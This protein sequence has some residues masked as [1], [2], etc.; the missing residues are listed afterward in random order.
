[1]NL[2]AIIVDDEPLAARR[3]QI[4]LETIGGVELLG[5]A[6]DG[7]KALDLVRSSSPDLI[8]LDIKMPVMGGLDVVR[9]LGSAPIPEIIFVTAFG[10]YAIPAFE[11]GAVGYVLKPINEEQ[12]RIA[13]ERARV[14]LRSRDAEE[15]LADLA[16]LLDRLQRAEPPEKPL[17]DQDLWT[18]SGTTIERVAVAD[19]DWFEAAGDYVAVHCGGRELLLHDSLTSLTE[20]LDPDKFARVHRRAIVRL[21]AIQA[22]KRGNFGALILV[23]VS[24]HQVPVSRTYKRIVQSRVG[25]AGRRSHGA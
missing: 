13:V 25:P 12:L 14:K 15:R 19:V 2:R 24:G 16:A 17:F 23:M 7:A 10:D 6:S 1:M 20:R 22:L 8:L 5:T 9:A 18:A 11:A 21:G 3:L 4:A